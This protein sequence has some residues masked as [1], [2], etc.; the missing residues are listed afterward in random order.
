MTK[1]GTVV[2]NETWHHR[3][4]ERS[5][6][7]LHQSQGG[8]HG[9]TRPAAL[10]ICNTSRCSGVYVV[11]KGEL[12]CSQAPTI[13]GTVDRVDVDF[14]EFYEREWGR[15]VR[16]A[17][18]LVGEQNVAEDVAQE[19]F[20]GLYENWA[21]VRHPTTYFRTAIT[22]RCRNVL[23][24]RAVR[25][26]AFRGSVVDAPPLGDHL[27]D[28]VA[29]LPFRQRAVVVLRYYEGQTD[30]DIAAVLAVPEGTV[31]SDHARAIAALR[32][33]LNE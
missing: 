5:D 20:I 32:R 4:P 31:R 10:E 3:F 15:A 25:S 1:C 21:R 27:T 19:C 17:Y 28:V 18:L 11:M 16:Y 12:A 23:R 8:S 29:R 26:R 33:H 14:S 13:D 9:R 24:W 30:R 2:T 6:E 7:S 22:N